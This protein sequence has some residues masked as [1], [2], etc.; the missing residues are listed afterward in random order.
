MYSIASSASYL[1]STV[2]V[3]QEYERVWTRA[4]PLHVMS[5]RMSSH[6]KRF[7]WWQWRALAAT[8]YH[9]ESEQNLK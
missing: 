6:H 8:T 2:S 4:D 7:D 5:C 9:G 3:D 1:A